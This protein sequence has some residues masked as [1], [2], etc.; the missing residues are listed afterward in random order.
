M[1]NWIISIVLLLGLWLLL[2][3]SISVEVIVSGAI[4]AMLIIFIFSM[5]HPVFSEMNINPRTLLYL[6]AYPF[7]FFAA[8]IRANIDVALRVLS[9]SLPIKPAI[10]E[11]K[12]RLNYRIGRLFLAN[13][14]TL[15][16]GTLSV[17]I[18][19]DSLFIHWIDASSTD[20]EKATRE[21]V[22]GF[23]KYLE[24]IYG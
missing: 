13:S 10:V 12:T 17:D 15:T 4:A 5:R 19:D 2:N 14:I 3:G 20:I 7:V 8:L 22:R 11:V 16:P 9:P 18:V 1:K 24:V 21:I 23:E 6:A